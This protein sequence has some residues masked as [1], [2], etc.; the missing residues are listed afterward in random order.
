MIRHHAEQR[1]GDPLP[2][3]VDIL[4]AAAGIS[5]SS[6]FATQPASTRPRA[7]IASTV[8]SA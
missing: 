4:F 2:Q 5:A 7:A 6:T 8:S 3:G 1:R